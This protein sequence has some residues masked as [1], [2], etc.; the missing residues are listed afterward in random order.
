MVVSLAACGASGDAS[1]DPSKAAAT[2]D[3]LSGGVPSDIPS[4]AADPDRAVSAP[5]KFDGTLY[6]DDLLV[7]SDETIDTELLK[8]VT[9][10]TV[11]GKPGVAAYEQLSYGQ[12]SIENKVFNIAAVDPGRYRAFTGQRSAEFADQ[13]ERLAGGEV[14]VAQR[15]QKDLPVDDKGYLE[16][17]KHSIHVGA[18]S[19]AEVD[20]VDVMVNEKW[21]AELD[22]PRRNAVVINTGIA[23]PQAVREQI[24][25]KVGKDKLSIIA[26]DIVAQRG[27]DLDTF[28][29]VVPV[30][31][32]SDAV[33]VFRYNP[34]GGGRIAPDPAW[35]KKYIV[36]E[37]VPILGRVTC[38]RHMMP[39]LKAALAEV[40]RRGLAD[41]I[42]ADEYAGC[43]Y[44]RF[45]A[46]SSSLSNHSFGLALDFNVP[47][48]QRGTVGEMNREVVAIFKLW[49]FAWGGDWSW[50]DPMHFELA[51]IVSPG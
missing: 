27:L 33:G 7:V 15:L 48:N 37:A 36:T 26:L 17:G 11:R 13:W 21:G 25:K 1:D 47:G 12:F 2:A 41:E 29:T 20:S 28:Q 49:G 18:Y 19:P 16:I 8:Q 6:G 31:S 43:Y 35:V 3:G 32:F 5:G 44:P 9:G 10:V 40:Q 14:A 23:S 45:I 22:L 38:N 51:R 42:H 39:Q 24:E 34:I 4:D 46:G 30:G 50:T